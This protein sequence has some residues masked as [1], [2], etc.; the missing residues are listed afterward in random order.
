MG[1]KTPLEEIYVKLLDAKYDLEC[2]LMVL[3][4]L[5]EYYTCYS[6]DL[7]N[8]KRFHSVKSTIEQI[9]QKLRLGINE[10]DLYLLNIGD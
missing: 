7:E 10:L 5:E 2:Y 3:A 9:Y 6:D 8:T 4:E 1:A